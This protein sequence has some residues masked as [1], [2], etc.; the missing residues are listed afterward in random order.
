VFPTAGAGPKLLDLILTCIAVILWYAWPELGPWPLVLVVVGRVS[1]GLSRSGGSPPLGTGATEGR[2]QRW[3][4]TRFD[5]PLLL[6]LVSAAL[7]AALAFDRGAASAK[8]WQIVGGLALY[9]SLVFAPEEATV[10]GHRVPPVHGVL[11]VLPATIAAYFLLTADWTLVLGKLSWLDPAV[12][13]FAGQQPQ[14][15]LDPL[16]PNVAGGLI[17]ALIPLQVAAALEMRRFGFP[18]GVTVG[19]WTLVVLSFLGLLMTASRGAW[20]ALAAAGAVWLLWLLWGH[21]WSRRTWLVLAGLL[22]LSLAAGAALVWTWGPLISPGGRVELL[23]NSVDLA[24]DTPFTGIGLGKGIIQMAYSSYVLLVHVGHTIHSHILVL[25]IWLEQGLLGLAAFT[26]L[27][28]AAARARY[29][30]PVWRAAGLASLGVILVHG[31]ADDAFYGSRGVVLLFVPLAVLA[32]EDL[33]AGPLPAM[34]S[35]SG[36]PGWGSRRK[37]AGLPR[38][39]TAGLLG[40]ATVI[41]A[42]ALMP[43]VRAAFQANLGALAQTRAELSV[44]RWPEWPVQDALR[45]SPDPNGGLPTVELE[46]AIAR[47]RAALALDPANVTA[48]RRLGQIELS[49]GEIDAAQRH[50]EAA[51]AAAPDQRATRQMLGEVYALAGRPAEAAS[52]WQTLDLDAGQ[53]PIR[54]GWYGILG[55]TE[56]AERIEEAAA[57]LG[58]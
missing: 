16:H 11:L 50:L 43:P 31:L 55:E 13:W 56:N 14:P 38:R 17:A 24:L 5:L 12:Q 4:R 47:Y 3:M 18:V 39:G 27:L 8:F 29:A 23:R 44:Y 34:A 1:R 30:S 40:A 58:P 10:T 36:L 28:V 22:A 54:I 52:L 42:L 33:A 35:P 19:G 53:L 32:R 15:G 48:N 9:D 20:I 26:W 7:G 6:F 41:L 2:K 37:L 49:R 46:P 25:N 21:R 57:G 51:Y 45:R